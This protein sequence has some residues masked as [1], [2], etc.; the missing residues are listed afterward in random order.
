MSDEC[1]ELK[2]IKY[3]TM[4]LN[5]NSKISETIPNISNIERFLT[6]EK[7]V[8]QNKPWNKLNKGTRIKLITSFTEEYQLQNKI[9]DELKLELRTYL[10]LCLERKKLNKKQDLV[11]DIENFKII[12]IQNLIFNKIKNKFTLKRSDKRVSSLKSLAP[13]NKTTKR[14]KP[15]KNK[16]KNEKRIKKDTDK[17]KKRVKKDK[18]STKASNKVSED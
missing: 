14:N 8:T 18:V 6:E 2:N 16:V 13:K 10:K 1:M 4:L 15:L 7:E 5:N 12:S 9:S 17:K 3:Q 11:Y